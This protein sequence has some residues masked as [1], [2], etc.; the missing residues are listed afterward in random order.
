M[1]ALSRST[2]GPCSRAAEE[3]RF[4]MVAVIWLRCLQRHFKPD[5]HV[6]FEGVVWLLPFIFMFW[7]SARGDRGL[8][9][10]RGKARSSGRRRAT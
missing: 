1:P 10:G 5:H 3:G 4:I 9:G 7:L 6:A 2:F 8:Q